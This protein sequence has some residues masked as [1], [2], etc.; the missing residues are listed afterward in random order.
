MLHISIFF[1][2]FSLIFGFFLPVPFKVTLRSQQPSSS[3][4][5]NYSHSWVHFSV[6]G[7]LFMTSTDLKFL[8]CWN[9]QALNLSWASHKFSIYNFWSVS[10]AA[11][12]NNFWHGFFLDFIIW[13][14]IWNKVRPT[15]KKII[16]YI[17][18]LY[19]I[20]LKF[21]EILTQTVLDW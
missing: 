6:L 9:Q 8:S 21:G 10:C 18:T 2:P 5:R 17:S 15:T 1:P 20:F 7:V 12:K 11:K 14:M 16:I 19:K 4:C 13:N 3:K